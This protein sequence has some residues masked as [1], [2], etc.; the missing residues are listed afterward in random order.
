MGP[1]SW[2]LPWRA[3]ILSAAEEILIDKRLKVEDS[4]GIRTVSSHLCV[5][6]A[7]RNSSHR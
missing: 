2:C 7:R 6:R 4:G 3:G 5:A 1:F